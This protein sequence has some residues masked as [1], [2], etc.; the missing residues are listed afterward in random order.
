M[1]MKL[2]PV[3]EMLAEK[4]LN[5]LVNKYLGETLSDYILLLSIGT[6]SEKC[7]NCGALSFLAEHG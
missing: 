6:L 3:K 1:M 4:T 2:M 5:S 7:I